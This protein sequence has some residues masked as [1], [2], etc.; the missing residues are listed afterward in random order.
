MLPRCPTA[1]QGL[2]GGSAAGFAS[3][4][5]TSDRGIV[6]TNTQMKQK[7][8]EMPSLALQKGHAHSIFMRR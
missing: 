3:H 6:K 2:A 5:G 8:R 1:S 7:R 4:K